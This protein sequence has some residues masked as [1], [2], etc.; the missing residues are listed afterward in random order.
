MDR[1]S[2]RHE[3]DRGQ[4]FTLEGIVGGVLV[5]TAL[6]FA[7]QSLLVTPTTGG[8]VDPGVR[9]DLRQ[10]ADDALVVSAQADEMD[11]ST[12]VRYWDQREQTFACYTEDGA[13]ICP[14]NK[15]I[16]FGRQQP[17]GPLG[18]ILNQTFESRAQ[19][20]NIH[21]RFRGKSVGDGA[22]EVPIV[23]RGEPSE[24]AVVAT[25]RVA[26][27]DDMALTSPGANDAQLSEYDTDPVDNP[28]PEQSGYYP[29][30]DAYPSSP[31]YNIVEVRL[32]VW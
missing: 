19:T 17:P 27:F 21:M 26:L 23:Y 32:V 30:P 16:G 28:D 3:R 8:A 29:V 22:E 5:L 13:E 25:Y 6:L 15:R 11:L 4:A 12:L 31:L 20:Y 2:T 14:V 24:T 18:D 1:N 7:L 9:S 10:Q